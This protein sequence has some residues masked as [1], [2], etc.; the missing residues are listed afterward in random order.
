MRRIFLEDPSV[1]RDNIKIDLEEVGAEIM[2]WIQW[3][4]SM[5]TASSSSIKI[6]R[7]SN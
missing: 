4:T 2:E 1:D 5:N 3:R 6:E 7:L